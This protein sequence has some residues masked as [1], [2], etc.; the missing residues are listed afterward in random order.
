ML[1]DLGREPIPAVADLVHP[2]AA[3]PATV[4]AAS[5]ERRDNAYEQL[6]DVSDWSKQFHRLI[7][8]RNEP[9]TLVEPPGAIIFGVDDNGE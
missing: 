7:E 3:Y 8:K 5:P 2:R 9:L 4:N 6:P 1:N